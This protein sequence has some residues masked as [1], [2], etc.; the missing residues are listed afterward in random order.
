MADILNLEMRQV[1]THNH[2]FTDE[3]MSVSLPDQFKT[4]TVSL[5]EGTTDIDDHIEVFEGYLVLH[6]YPEA[7][8]C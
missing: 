7:I 8:L 1:N 6:G 5:Y 3:I 4:P 2:P